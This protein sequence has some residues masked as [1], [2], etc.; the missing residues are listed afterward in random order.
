MGPLLGAPGLTAGIVRAGAGSL[1]VALC[2]GSP[3]LQGTWR[4]SPNG[5]AR[6]IAALPPGGIPN[7]MALDDR[8]RLLYVADSL[9]SVVWRAPPAARPLSAPPSG[10]QPAPRRRLPAAGSHAPRTHRP[11]R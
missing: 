4:V 6:R 2:T 5:S 8:H 1:C 11:P 9:L 7:G 3:N 10:P